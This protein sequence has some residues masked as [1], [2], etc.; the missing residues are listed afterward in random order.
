[1]KEQSGIYLITR[2][3]V[4]NT[5]KPDKVRVVFDCAATCKEISLNNALMKGPYLMNNLT[6][7]LICFRQERIALDGDIKA[8][9]HQVMVDPVYINIL[10]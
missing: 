2:S 3:S 5:N 1:M 8:M 4:P 9:F 6:E 10:R 7:V